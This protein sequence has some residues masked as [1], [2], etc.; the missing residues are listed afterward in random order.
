MI[1]RYPL[2]IEHSHGIDGPFIDGLPIKNGGFSMAMLVITRGYPHDSGNH[3]GETCP[4]FVRRRLLP[5]GPGQS[6]DL[7]P[8]TV[9]QDVRT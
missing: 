9:F 7:R 4:E 8:S 5:H 1:R 6:V 2:V 3:S